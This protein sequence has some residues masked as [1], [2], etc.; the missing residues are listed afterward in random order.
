MIFIRSI[1]FGY[2]VIA[3]LSNAICS[4]GY[5]KFPFEL[6]SQRIQVYSLFDFIHT[7]G[8]TIFSMVFL[9]R[10]RRTSII[11]LFAKSKNK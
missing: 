3:S 6:A 7:M 1:I 4:I 8:N 11:S 5:L 2:F 10:V 9:F